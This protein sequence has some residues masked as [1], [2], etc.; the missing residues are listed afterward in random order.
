MT[1]QQATVLIVAKEEGAKGGWRDLGSPVA[2]VLI[3]GPTRRE[4]RAV[5]SEKLQPT[6]SLHSP[7]FSRIQM[8]TLPTTMF[9]Q[10]EHLTSAMT[11]K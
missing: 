5:D 11:M 6:S 3:V 7:I 9:S 1:C 10:Q 4:A 8:C 2:V